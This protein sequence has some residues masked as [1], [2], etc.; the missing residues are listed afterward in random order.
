MFCNFLLGIGKIWENTCFN[1]SQCTHNKS[2]IITSGIDLPS[3]R[4]LAVLQR[5]I[6]RHR[7]HGRSVW[8]ARLYRTPLRGMVRTIWGKLP[9]TVRPSPPRKWY[10]D[11]LLGRNVWRNTLADWNLW[12]FPLLG[13][14]SVRTTNA[15]HIRNNSALIFN[16]C[17][18]TPHGRNIC[19]FVLCLC[20]SLN[21]VCW[22]SR[23]WKHGLSLWAVCVM[24][25]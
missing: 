18:E 7:Q 19:K 22:L 20:I 21:S 1:K 5:K 3:L 25:N 8:R 16:V 9:Q 23:F 4:H 17:A 11:R 6:V 2:W 15:S 24:P 10:F 12:T 14:S 13:V